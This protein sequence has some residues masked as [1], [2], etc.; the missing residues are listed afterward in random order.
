LGSDG[1]A[2]DFQLLDSAELYEAQTGE[3]RLTGTMASPRAGH[4]ST[5]M[6]DGRVLL[7]GGSG[8]NFTTINGA[9]LFK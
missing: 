9:E 4:T 6:A 1:G 7:T 5:L 3:F 2:F 8:P